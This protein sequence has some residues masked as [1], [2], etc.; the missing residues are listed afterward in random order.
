[1]RDGCLTVGKA[2]VRKYAARRGFGALSEHH[3][4]VALADAARQE[5]GAVQPDLA[6]AW[7]RWGANMAFK[8]RLRAIFSAPLTARPP[9]SAGCTPASATRACRQQAA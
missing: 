3:V 4:L 8:A 2:L 6:A 5:K 9:P 1:M 7:K